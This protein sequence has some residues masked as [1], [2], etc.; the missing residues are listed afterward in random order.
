MTHKSTYQRILESIIFLGPFFTIFALFFLYPFFNGIFLSLTDLRGGA[1][2]FSFVG[3]ENYRRAFTQ[4][5]FF[6]ESAW[7]TI[8]FTIINLL[9]TNIIAMFFAVSLSGKILFNK[10]IRMVIFLPNMISMV[11]VGFIWRYLFNQMSV[12]IDPDKWYG[13]LNQSWLSN[14]NLVIYSVVIVSVWHGVGYIMTIYIAG[15]QDID[16]QII[17]ASKIDGASDWQSFWKVKLPMMRGVFSVGLFINLAGSLK[18][19]DLVLSL[20]A[21]GPGRS[22][23]VLMLNIYREAFVNNQL[24]YGAAKAMILSIFIIIL[25]LFQFTLTKEK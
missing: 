3:I 15:L 5:I 16:N 9:A 20:T 21:G 10:L 23:E 6:R 25:G 18:I 22:S 2:A 12:T 17:D 7:N 24:G 1:T 4:D 13:F 19:F 14:P 11:V 8:N